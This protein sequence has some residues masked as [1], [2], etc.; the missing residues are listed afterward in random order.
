ML[1]QFLAEAIHPNVILCLVE[2]AQYYMNTF[3]YNNYNS[4]QFE[5]IF[6]SF[7]SFASQNKEWKEAQHLPISPYESFLSNI[8]ECNAVTY[9][10]IF[11]CGN[12][13]KFMHKSSFI[14]SLLLGF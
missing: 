4:I 14:I 6:F 13:M 3:L 5:K 10:H 2:N 11:L 1:L 7:I 9:S 8:S 12:K